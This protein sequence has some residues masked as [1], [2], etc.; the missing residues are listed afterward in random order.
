LNL[1]FVAC[2]VNAR[3]CWQKAFGVWNKQKAAAHP[4][5]G[6]LLP[7]EP[8]AEQIMS[9]AATLFINR[10]KEGLLSPAPKSDAPPP[11]PP[12]PPMTS[13][14]QEE[15][16]RL[17]QQLVMSG[18]QIEGLIKDQ[19]KVADA[20]S[21]TS[22]QAAAVIATMTKKLADKVKAQAAAAAQPTGA[23]AGPT[24]GYEDDIPF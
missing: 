11:P 2:L 16:D 1:T 3:D 6:F 13:E 8:T 4:D 20:F 15:I 9:T 19:C 10:V 21:I 18:D 24:G 17:G 14:Q 5:D 23:P 22:E 12:P 7:P